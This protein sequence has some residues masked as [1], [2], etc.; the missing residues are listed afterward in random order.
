MTMA[1]NLNPQ[2]SANSLN[3]E[4]SIIS[5]P[6]KP[7]L[8]PLDIARGYG[9]L[10]SI[11]SVLLRSSS[12]AED[13]ATERGQA[14]NQLAPRGLLTIMAILVVVAVLVSGRQWVKSLRLPFLIPESERILVNNNSNTNQSIAD[15][16]ALQNKDTDAD[17]LS[18][19]DELYLYQ[20]SPYLEDS[21]SDGFNDFEEIKSNNDPNCPQGQ[22][23]RV[24]G[25]AQGSELLSSFDNLANL[26]TEQ[27][28]QMLVE[29]G[30]SLEEVNKFSETEL[31][32]VYEETLKTIQQPD[33]FTPEQ[34]RQLLV[35]EGMKEEEV[36]QF[37]DEELLSFWQ[38][39]AASA[40][41]EAS[42]Q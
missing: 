39:V 4:K 6:K 24:Q 21:D 17:G 33:Y 30:M 12:T 42:S 38:E 25:S 7:R 32:Q 20:T 8:R 9:R 16:L 1:D 3:D 27:I 37:S 41:Q 35:A 29:Q 14:K 23:C 26:S 5:S 15:I 36:A 2:E 19:Y 31:R 22:T 13:G 34:I 11:A 28:K 40:E 10:R 18:D